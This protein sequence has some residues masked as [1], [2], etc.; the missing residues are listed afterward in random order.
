MKQ[1]VRFLVNPGGLQQLKTTDFSLKSAVFNV[2][3]T[4]INL[5]ICLQLSI[6]NFTTPIDSRL[7]MKQFLKSVINPGGLQKLKIVGFLLQLK[8]I[9]DIIRFFFSFY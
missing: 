6:Q 8:N 3:F 2:F 4:I 5:L 1:F 9:H 7:L